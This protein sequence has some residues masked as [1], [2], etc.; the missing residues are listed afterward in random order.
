MVAALVSVVAF[1]AMSL[2]A[3][4]RLLVR[5][6]TLVSGEGLTRFRDPAPSGDGGLLFRGTTEVVTLPDDAGG[7]RTILTSGT[8]APDLAGETINSFLDVRSTPDDGFVAVLA[9]LNGTTADQ[10]IFVFEAGR[11]STV[12]SRRVAAGERLSGPDLNGK[13]DLTFAADEGVFR[14]LRATGQTTL[15][16]PTGAEGVPRRPRIDED[17]AVIWLTDGGLFHWSDATGTRVV[18]RTGAPG[19]PGSGTI[20]DLLRAA[21]RT[22]GVA[23]VAETSSADSV[24]LW[25]AA[26]EETR[27]LARVGDSTDG[28]DIVRI[29]PRVDFRPD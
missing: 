12:V 9:D 1:A 20:T 24:F 28:G 27:L 5:S 29:R 14:R 8:P 19:P 22:G 18:A 4:P 10:G 16:V 3:E 2:A 23:F 26:L 7:V 11:L 21:V 15:V 17:G 13:G 6:G 25:D